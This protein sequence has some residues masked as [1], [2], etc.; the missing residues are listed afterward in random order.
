M[1]NFEFVTFAIVTR[2]KYTICQLSALSQDWTLEILFGLVELPH[3]SKTEMP[4][5]SQS[6]GYTCQVSRNIH[7]AELLSQGTQSITLLQY[8]KS[9]YRVVM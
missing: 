7:L 3:I 6:W 4:T 5:P 8:C 9:Y 2:V 1:F